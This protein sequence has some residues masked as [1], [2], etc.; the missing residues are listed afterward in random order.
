M[1]KR[2]SRIMSRVETRR[3]FI[4]LEDCEFPLDRSRAELELPC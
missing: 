3:G 1:T 2:D 4:P